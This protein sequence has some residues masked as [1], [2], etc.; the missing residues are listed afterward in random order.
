MAS[1]TLAG[2]AD[3]YA[4]RLLHGGQ[5]SHT[6]GN[7]TLSSRLAGAGYAFS[8]AAENI[9]YQ[10]GREDSALSVLFMQSWMASAGHRRNILNAR[11]TELGVGTAS[12]DGATYAVQ[13][14]A[15]PR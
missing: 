3:G 2:L 13:V 14:F 15:T 11:L 8:A 7:T 4:Q 9:A 12:G 1:A 6:L 10:R 5:L